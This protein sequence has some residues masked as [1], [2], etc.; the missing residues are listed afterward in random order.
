MYVRIYLHDMICMIYIYVHVDNYY[1][2]YLYV[3]YVLYVVFVYIVCK[4]AVKSEI[5]VYN[6]KSAIA[7]RLFPKQ[8]Y[9]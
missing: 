9:L 5:H 4:D 1:M 3:L 7:A 2:M 6:Q 8:L